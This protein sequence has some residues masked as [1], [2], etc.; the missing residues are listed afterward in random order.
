MDSENILKHKIN[1]LS[2][3]SEQALKLVQ[4]YSLEFWSIIFTS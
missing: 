1:P 2:V 4:E 3:F